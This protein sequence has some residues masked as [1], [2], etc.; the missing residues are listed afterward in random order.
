MDPSLGYTGVG[1]SVVWGCVPCHLA[2]VA[3][4]TSA[5]HKKGHKLAELPSCHYYVSNMFLG[6]KGSWGTLRIPR[7]YWGNLGNIG[8]GFKYF[9]FSSRSL[10]KWSN[11]TSIFF[12]GVVQPPTSAVYVNLSCRVL[13]YQHCLVVSLF[14]LMFTPSW[15]SVYPFCLIKWKLKPPHGTVSS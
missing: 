12:K 11:L 7:D 15:G 8:G 13:K 5:C 4:V 6:N 1:V 3:L 14:F 10:G 2:L 9:L